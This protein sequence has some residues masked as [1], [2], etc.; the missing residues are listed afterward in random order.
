M[1]NPSDELKATIVG[2]RAITSGELPDR[3]NPDLVKNVENLSKP[4]D[5]LVLTQTDIGALV[6]EDGGH[7]LSPV[8]DRIRVLKP[9]VVDPHYLAAMLSGSWN[10]RFLVGTTIQRAK[11][12]D[13]EI[14]LVPMDDQ[15]RLIA[16]LAEVERLRDAAETITAASEN[17]SSSLL[18]AVRF[19][20]ELDASL[21]E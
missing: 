9:D 14:P 5:V 10:R 4:S 1:R 8:V 11:L 19:N 18:D 15:K 17:L 16:A 13:L 20:I 6:D 21:R 2:A 3:A 12:T 7:Y